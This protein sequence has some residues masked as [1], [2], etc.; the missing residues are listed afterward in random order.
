MRP[1]LW[2][3]KKQQALTGSDCWW[4]DGGGSWS[5]LW[6]GQCSYFVCGQTHLTE[7]LFL[8]YLSWSQCGLA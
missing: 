1:K 2:L 7:V 3:A 8:S 6:F 4:V 5:F